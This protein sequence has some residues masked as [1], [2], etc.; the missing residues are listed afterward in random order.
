MYMNAC[1]ALHVYIYMYVCVT[2]D[3]CVCNEFGHW[4]CGQSWHATKDL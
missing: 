2:V 3:I 1:I 4:V